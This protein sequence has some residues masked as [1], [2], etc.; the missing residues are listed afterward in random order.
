MRGVGVAFVLLAGCGRLGFAPPEVN[1]YDGGAGDAGPDDGS[2]VQAC[3]QKPGAVFC[4]GFED[5]SLDAWAQTVGSLVRQTAIV[6][7]GTAAARATTDGSQQPAGI[8]VT[9]FDDITS[10]SLHY[11]AWF[12]VPSGFA[13]DKIEMFSTNGSGSNLGTVFLVDQEELRV[14]AEPGLGHTVTTGVDVPRD[15]WFCIEVHVDVDASN[16]GLR[17]DLDGTT[18]GSGSGFGTLPTGGY[19]Y[20]GVGSLFLPAGQS[21]STVYVDDVAAGTQPLGCS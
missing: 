16:G 8:N 13:I 7:T 18:I 5:P 19:T 15:R 2:S 11:R 17:L 6:H 10:G 4:D 21:A 12:Y 14:Y 9:P 3:P 1:T 20:L